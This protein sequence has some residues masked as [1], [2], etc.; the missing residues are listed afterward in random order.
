MDGIRVQFPKVHQILLL[1]AGDLK[2]ATKCLSLPGSACAG[3]IVCL[4]IV[5]YLK[6]LIL[7]WTNAAHL[8]YR[9][10][11]FCFKKKKTGKLDME[12]L[13]EKEAV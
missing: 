5:C 6:V 8:S 1:P 9:K 3:C 13:R 7:F 12:V 2:A 10:R 4:N 11:F